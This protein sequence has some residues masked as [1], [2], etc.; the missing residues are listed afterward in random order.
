MNGREE[1]KV[2]LW[3]GLEEGLAWT[4]IE[5]GRGREGCTLMV[6]PRVWTGMDGNKWCRSGIVWMM[7]K[8]GMVKCTCVCMPH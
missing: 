5:K 3:E 4:E 8:L 6:S 7:S 2:G 1:D